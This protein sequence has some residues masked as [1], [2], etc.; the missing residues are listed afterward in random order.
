VLVVGD[1]A[2]AVEAVMA[3]LGPSV[4]ATGCTSARRALELCQHEPFDVVCADADLTS[5]PAAEMFR[6]LTAVLGHVGYL[7]LVSPT[8]YARSDADGRWHVVFKP[9]DPARLAGAVTQL[10]RLSQMRR[11]V[12][13]ISHLRR[14]GS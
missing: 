7:M 9:V 11:S 14:A 3:M 6:R 13:S 4:A 5:M 12:A 2:T 8:G 1:E 10:A